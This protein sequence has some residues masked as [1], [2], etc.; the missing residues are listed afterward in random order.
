MSATTTA[1][2]TA[3][4]GPAGS[5]GAGRGRILFWLAVL[6]ALVVLALV[7]GAPSP[8][9][10]LSPRSTAPEGT[11]GLVLFL[12]EL[13]ASVDI[14][15]G[16]PEPADDVALVL[17]DDLGDDRREQVLTWVHDGGTLVVADP[18]SPLAADR[19]EDGGDGLDFELS[20]RGSCDIG[21]LDGADLISIAGT[22]AFAV[23]S[24][25]F[26][27]GDD[28]ES[29]FGDGDTALIVAEREGAGSIVSVGDADLFTND[30]LDEDDN[31]VVAAGLL[32]PDDGT[33]L[34]FLDAPFQVRDRKLTDLIP[35]NVVRAF[36]QVVIAFALYAL[37]RSRRLGRPVAETQ[38][39]EIAGSEL[40]AAVGGLLEVTGAPYRAA[41][42]LRAELRRDLGVRFGIA[43]DTP[44][45]V[46]AQ[47]VARRTGADPS[48]LHS[49]LAAVPPANDAELTE[50][51][52]LI[53][54]VR[55]EVFRGQRA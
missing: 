9:I 27:V 30:N 19:A 15:R 14:G 46:T 40:V 6:A 13:G 31:A 42:L 53:H 35:D 48:R 32:A 49:A 4:T 20:A 51:A 17:S 45:D 18:A 52:R 34:R 43:P 50:V 10:P 54:S 1:T 7:A 47:I 37:W 3:S 22:F 33:S 41:E 21:A 24:S 12:E 55:Q 16:A 29:C 44:A 11:R 8:S 25:T 23:P 36:A 38:P 26:V 2:P 28:A 5:R 39:V